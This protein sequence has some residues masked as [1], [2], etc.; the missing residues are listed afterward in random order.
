MSETLKLSNQDR[1][2]VM[3]EL[4]NPSEPNES[5]KELFKAS[6]QEKQDKDNKDIKTNILLD[7]CCPGR[8]NLSR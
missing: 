8:F 3:T 1:D 7:I 5:L 2:L 6:T 4:E